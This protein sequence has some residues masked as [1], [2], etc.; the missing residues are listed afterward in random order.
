MEKRKSVF[1]SSFAMVLVDPWRNFEGRE[2]A[3]PPA[4]IVEPWPLHS[5]SVLALQHSND[6]DPS[7]APELHCSHHHLLLINHKE[8]KKENSIIKLRPTQN[9]VHIEVSP[10]P[11]SPAACPLMSNSFLSSRLNT[12]RL[13]TGNQS[14]N[15]AT[16]TTGPIIS[17][18]LKTDSNTQYMILTRI[19]KQ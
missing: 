13:R 11:T 16:A 18:C 4:P 9:R 7:R 15:L 8:R 6:W 14:N 2:Q 5:Q 1:T 19:F 3:E 17:T 10:I 12:F